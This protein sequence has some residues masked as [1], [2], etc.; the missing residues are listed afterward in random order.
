[1]H[2]SDFALFSVL[3]SSS[4]FSLF[5]SIDLLAVDSVAVI[6]HVFVPTVYKTNNSIHFISKQATIASNACLEYSFFSF[7]MSVRDASQPTNY[8]YNTL[9]RYLLG[10]IAAAIFI[11]IVVTL[12]YFQAII[13]SYS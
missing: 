1:M 2:T 5:F 12:R 10:L 6:E 11:L 9:S 7:T 13:S 4:S 3:P 8:K